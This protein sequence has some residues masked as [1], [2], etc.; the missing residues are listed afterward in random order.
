M[1]TTMFREPPVS[2]GTQDID[3]FRP[4]ALTTMKASAMPK[5]V[6]LTREYEKC[7]NLRIGFPKSGNGRVI[8]LLTLL[9]IKPRK[10]VK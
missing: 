8:Y 3:S 6:V 5:F 1:L 7:S 4:K 9:R 2:D 10:F